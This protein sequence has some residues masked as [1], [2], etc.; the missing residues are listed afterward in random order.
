MDILSNLT[1]MLVLALSKFR[2]SCSRSRVR[3]MAHAWV[4][5][6]WSTPGSFNFMLLVQNIRR[7]SG[8]RIVPIS[9]ANITGA[10]D[11]YQGSDVAGLPALR[12]AT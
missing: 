12:S 5:C 10:G 11:R 8:K 7:I 1:S 2:A 6:H 3:H 9:T 4:T